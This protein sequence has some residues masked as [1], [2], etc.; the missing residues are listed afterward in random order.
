MS[1]KRSFHPSPLP[2][3]VLGGRGCSDPPSSSAQDKGSGRNPDGTFTRGNT[4]SVT[5]G[6]RSRQVQRAQLPAQAERRHQLAEKR[7]AIVD[8]LGGEA[9]LSRLQLDL[10]NRYL[11]LDTVASWLGGNLVAEGPLTAKG[12]SRAAL[13]AYL[14]VV[15]RLQRVS[16][17]LGLARRQTSVSLDHYLADTYSESGSRS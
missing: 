13:S 17:A 11:E 8:D 15:D 10:V 2:P 7:A 5:H 12:R 9:V 3:I 6:G 4:A 14:T 1:D 16:T